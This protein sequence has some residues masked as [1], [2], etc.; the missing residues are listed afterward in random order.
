MI[1]Y[2]PV[3]LKNHDDI[4]GKE[5][6]TNFI[7]EMQRYYEPFI[8]KGRSVQLA[9]ETWE[10]AVADSIFGGHWV[11]AG[12]NIMDVTTP[13]AN[14]D[15]KGLSSNSLTSVSTEASILQNNKLASDNFTSLFKQQDFNRLK[16]MFIDPLASKISKAGN[17]YLFCVVR[18]KKKNSMNFDVYYCLY[19]VAIE[20][21]PTLVEQMSLDGNRSINIP[22]ID[23]RYGRCYLYIPK[24]RIELR[25]N[26]EGMKDFLVFSHSV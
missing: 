2:E 22:V 16:E 9:K 23:I 3:P 13:N 7:E 4:L 26:M 10:Y 1:R 19:K 20:D 8:T 15:V 11:G 6:N 17:L 24:R 12:K 5:F 18:H 25:V 14:I 21:N